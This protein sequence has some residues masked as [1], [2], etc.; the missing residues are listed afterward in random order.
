MAHHKET[1]LPGKIS[2]LVSN[3]LS[4]RSVGE[5]CHSGL[6]MG[7]AGD[8]DVR[9]V[10]CSGGERRMSP[11]VNGG[12]GPTPALRFP[13]PATCLRVRHAVPPELDGSPS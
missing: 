4:L 8:G 11:S 5:Q 3:M 13:P 9:G 6:G 2:S 12:E 7:L 1:R 10:T